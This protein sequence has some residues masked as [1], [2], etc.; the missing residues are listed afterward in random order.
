MPRPPI[1]HGL[2]VDPWE[3]ISSGIKDILEKRQST[4]S[5]ASLHAAVGAMVSDPTSNRLTDG[6]CMILQARFSEW[7]SLLARLTGR[8]IIASFCSIYRDFETYCS[9]IPKFYMLFDRRHDPDGTGPSETRRL[10]RTWFAQ[11]IFRDEALMRATTT[12]LRA[13]IAAARVHSDDPGFDDGAANLPNEQTVLAMYYS[14]HEEPPICPIF[15]RFFEEFQTE[16]DRYYGGFFA[17]K[18][19]SL[20]FPEYLEEASLRFRREEAIL[21]AV[22]R[23]KEQESALTILHDK[24]LLTREEDYLTAPDENTPPHIAAALAWQDGRCIKW[25]VDMYLRFQSD[26]SNVY[27]ACAQYV[28]DQMVALV[29]GFAAAQRAP[30][31]AK[32]I[33][34]LISTTQK[35]TA[36]FSR[37]F[38]EV[39]KAGDVLE[40]KIRQAWNLGDFNISTNFCTYIDH[41]I[42]GEFK[43]LS[44][45]EKKTFNETVALFYTRLEDKKMFNEFYVNGMVR[46]IIKMGQKLRELESPVIDAIRRAKAADFAKPFPEYMK[47]LRDSREYEDEFRQTILATQSD[48]RLT[49]L[50]FS[51]LVFDHRTFPLDKVDAHLLPK[52]LDELNKMFIQYYTRK[53]EKTKLTLLADV[54]IVDCKF[55]VPRN[56]KSPQPRT[57]TVSSDITCASILLFIYE[58]TA[59]GGI[60]LRELIDNIGDKNSVGQYLVRLCASTC[61]MVK[62]MAKGTKMA[63]DDMFQ[64][65]PQFF[66]AATKVTIQPIQSERKA[67]GKVVGV[68]VDM[69]KSQAIKA[70]AVRVLKMKNRVEQSA[71]ENDIIQALMPH[72]RADVAQIKRELTALE[73]EDF[74]ERQIVGGQTILVYTS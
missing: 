49:K 11:A 74:V 64:L 63:D 31:V 19:A 50:T 69:D 44:D 54:S 53:H 24:L 56:A 20:P 27:T 59:D 9:I 2:T 52:E 35:H 57:Y 38:R 21:R 71:L 28:H 17:S 25:L 65:N 14:F 6:L 36:P 26:L 45:D 8:P 7:R 29:P 3:T 5:L 33:G 72:F 62:R 43:D 12:S 34:E 10:I 1:A 42:K 60:S 48:S 4:L 16:M 68:K 55:N 51:P 67:D 22:L 18:Y 58:R 46:R 70:A 41:H 32:A 47:K 39:P 23:P 66:F 13:N 61:P 37:A 40:E 15:S 73:G 30:D